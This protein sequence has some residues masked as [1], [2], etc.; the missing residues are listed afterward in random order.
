MVKFRGHKTLGGISASWSNPVDGKVYS[1]TGQPD[2]GFNSE[3]GAHA[4]YDMNTYKNNIQ[5]PQCQVS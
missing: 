4:I 1:T 3:I 5:R 2:N